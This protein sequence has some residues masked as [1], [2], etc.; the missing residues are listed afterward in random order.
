VTPLALVALVG[1]GLLLGGC[2]SGP[3]AFSVTASPRVALWQNRPVRVT[4]TLGRFAE[5]WGCAAFAVLWGDGSHSGRDSDHDPAEEC[6]ARV[7]FEHVYRGPGE[8]LV[9]A[10]GSIEGRVQQR[11]TTVLIVGDRE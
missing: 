1:A 10:R 7:A 6:P 3:G 2:A 11:E 8:Y 4:A 9:V 5:R